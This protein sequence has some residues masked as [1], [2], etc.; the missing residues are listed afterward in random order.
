MTFYATDEQPI[1][2]TA[3]L[4]SKM[5]IL[6]FL[7]SLRARVQSYP[8]EFYIIFCTLYYWVYI[9]VENKSHSFF[10]HTPA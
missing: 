5:T 8:R 2:Q 7:L 1:G 10:W 4:I 3:S 9:L 6:I